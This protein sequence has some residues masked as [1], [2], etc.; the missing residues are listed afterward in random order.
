MKR[1]KFLC[2]V[3]KTSIKMKIA[4]GLL[5]IAT[6]LVA[7]LFVFALRAPTFISVKVNKQRFEH[8]VVLNFYEFV[9]TFGQFFISWSSLLK[10]SRHFLE[11]DYVRAN[12]SVQP[13]VWSGGRGPLPRCSAA[14][15]NSDCKS[16]RRRVVIANSVAGV[17]RGTGCGRKSR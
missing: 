7:T 3:K 11:R 8:L 13:L 14:F 6:D 5:I 9:N 1:Q 2:F 15:R 16:A 12:G 10:K 4:I 17:A